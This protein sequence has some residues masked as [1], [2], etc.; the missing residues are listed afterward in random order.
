MPLASTILNRR[1]V[2]QLVALLGL[3]VLMGHA[4]DQIARLGRRPLISLVLALA[5]IGCATSKQSGSY[6]AYQGYYPPKRFDHPFP[7]V[8][9][10]RDVTADVAWR[11]CPY[12]GWPA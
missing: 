1:K 6:M 9:I 4:L 7:G 3:V 5:L 2:M 10:V 12:Y 8:T 11:H